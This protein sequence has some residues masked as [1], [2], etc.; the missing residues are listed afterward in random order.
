MESDSKLD[1]LIN[2]LAYPKKNTVKK[3]F[4]IAK[5]ARNA[6]DWKGPHLGSVISYKN[7]ILSIGWN[8]SK[9][10]PLQKKFNKYRTFDESVYKNSEHAEM[11]A[12]RTLL[13]DY[14]IKEI[15][16]SRVSI[17]I[18][19]DKKTGC[20][21]LAKP[22]PACE[23]AI[24]SLGIKNIFYTGEDSIVHEIYNKKEKE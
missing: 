4:K 24:R 15:D 23:M 1:K 19:R 20:L 10:T 11:R 14:D 7:K 5:E 6:S 13:H 3:C 17:F 9:E 22:C 21:G 12:I 2:E 8:T 18:Y 16:F